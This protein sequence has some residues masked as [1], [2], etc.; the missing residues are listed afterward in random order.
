V[1]IDPK[2]LVQRPSGK[3]TP[4][5]RSDLDEVLEHVARRK[6][7]T[8]RVVAGRLLPGQDPR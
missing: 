2:A 3:K 4:F 5:K 6:D 7:G 8:Y 1:E